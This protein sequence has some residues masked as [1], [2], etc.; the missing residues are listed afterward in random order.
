MLVVLLSSCNKPELDVK[1]AYYLSEA[2][3]SFERAAF[4][5]ALAFTDSVKGQ[6]P[7]LPENYFLRGRIYTELARFDL[8]DQAYE[9]AL[10]LDPEFRGAWINRGNLAIR[11]GE[12]KPALVM[13]KKEAAKHPASGVYL[14]MGRAYQELGVADSARM[15]YENALAQDSARATI[16]MRLGQL[17]GEQGDLEPAIAY[18]Q[19]GVALEPDNLHYKYALGALLNSN[20]DAESAISYLKPFADASPWHYWGHYNLGQAYQRL[21]Q[22]DEAAFY[23]AK[24]ES[25]QTTQTELDHWQMMAES[26]PQHLMLW[27]RFSFALK[28]AGNLVDAQRADKIAYA[29]APDYL[30]H[31]FEDSAVSAGHGKAILKIASGELDEAIEIYKALLRDNIQHDGLW[32]NLGVTY[33]THGRIVQARQSWN[34]AMKYNN[35]FFRARRYIED[36]DK[37][38]YDPDEPGNAP[39]KEG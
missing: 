22:T 33:A 18:T 16:Y 38:F 2:Q 34:T 31:A 27:L 17:L 21:N 5:I 25:L 13:Y 36:L 10:A 19:K 28:R 35:K 24:A 29:L 20:G 26:N 23:L 37:A 8:A 6:A 7:N 14:Q 15:A 11:K 3:Q 1:T 39:L 30:V 4:N 12:I 32:L 9:Q